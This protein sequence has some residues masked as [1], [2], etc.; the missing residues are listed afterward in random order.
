MFQAIRDRYMDCYAAMTIDQWRHWL[1]ACV[2]DISLVCCNLRYINYDVLTKIVSKTKIFVFLLSI[3]SSK[4]K[5][6]F[7]KVM[8]IHKS[9]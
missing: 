4:Y 3:I 7:Y 6:R 2:Y 5:S 8:Q 1:Q 9:R